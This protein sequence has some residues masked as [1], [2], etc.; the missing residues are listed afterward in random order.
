MAFIVCSF[1]LS[2]L[3]LLPMYVLA[4]TNGSIALGASLSTAGSTSWLSLSGGFA[5]G[6][7]QLE[8]NDLFLLSIW[9]ANIPD[10]T[11]VWYANGD[12]PAPN[13]S[14][15]NLTANS[16]LVLTSPQGEQLWKS[17][18]TIAGVVA[19]GVMNDTGN[20]VLENEQSA[21]LWETFKNATDTMLPGQILERGRKLSSRNSETD[22]S[23][24]HFQLDFQ[25]DGNLV[26]SGQ[27][28]FYSTKTTTGSIPGSEGLQLVFNDSG[29]F[30]ILGLNGGYYTFTA[31]ERAARDYYL[32]TTVSFD[33]VLAQYF[34]P[35]TSVGN[36]SW[37]PLWS[38]P[39]N[40][41]QKINADSGPSI[42]GYN[43]ICTYK[44]DESPNCECPTGYSLLD[45][46]DP[47]GSCYPAF[48]QG[49]E[50]E[51]SYA[52]DMYDVQ[53]LENTDWLS[54]SYMQLNDT[55]ADTCSQ[56]CLQD[57]LCAVAVYSNQ[58]C[59]KKKFP[60]LYGREDNNLNATTFIKLTTIKK[61]KSGTTLVHG[62][63]VLLGT[64]VFVIFM[65]GAAVCLGLFFSFRNKHA[66]FPQND[67][68]TNLHS[69]SHK[70]L[71]EATNGFNEELG[72]VAVKKLNC[73]IQDGEKEFKTELNIIGRTH[74]KNLVH[75]VGY[76]DEGQQRSLVYEFLSNGTLAGFLFGDDK[77]S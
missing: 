76:C 6:F 42:C 9:F 2:S 8:N 11:I 20:F 77:P 17:N 30:Y 62:G 64:S 28:P 37:V 21:K 22:Y 50:N 51:P 61:K 34:L 57:C 67:L 49:C 68:D 38:E 26:L 15:V 63:S 54:S 32:R 46:D 4:Q 59:H 31:E 16:G 24:G 5:F 25:D 71:E 23:S 12:K 7:R 41:C 60:L 75:L 45:P 65:L 13:G 70:E 48:K 35:K 29:S 53:V 43:N 72:K 10:K 3:L 69:F 39:S 27:R 36:I 18:Q 14:V 56:S 19:H 55:T 47:Y 66:R 1:L 40:I 52:Q 44:E 58:T 73:W 74:H 33:G